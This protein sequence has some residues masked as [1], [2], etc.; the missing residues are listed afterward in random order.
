[1]NKILNF[2]HNIIR[3]ANSL[4]DFKSILIPGNLNDIEQEEIKSYKLIF[5]S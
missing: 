2:A 3:N 4:A 1:M 5:K